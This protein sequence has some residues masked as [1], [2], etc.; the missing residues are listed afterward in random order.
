MTD[1]QPTQNKDL[2]KKLQ[3]REQRM[4]ALLQEA[5]QAQA[6]ALDRFRRAEA[7]LQTRTARLERAE[8]RLRLVRQQLEVL[9][10]SSP[11]VEP[12]VA[13]PTPYETGDTMG[14]T[15][16][17]PT[18]ESDADRVKEARAAAGAT[19]ENV[20]RAA[21]RAATVAQEHPQSAR[22]EPAEIAKIEAEEESVEAVAAVTIAEI[23]A[24]R[25]AE[26]E[27]LAEASSA[28]TREA[29]QRAQQA[30]AAL[31]EVRV[32]IRDGLLTGE[33]AETALQNAER[34][35]TRAQALLADAEAAEEQ[36]LDTAMNAEADAEVAEG[37]AYAV[38]D[39]A[40]PPS[41]EE[42]AGH[43]ETGQAQEVVEGESDV[44][45]KIPLVRP[46]ENS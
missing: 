34:E 23:A 32:A 35:V 22:A 15:P 27:A 28:Q 38:V 26:A 5:Q 2:R 33:E 19:E 46:Q 30:E 42:Q 31:G 10:A 45:I 8:E 17:A 41:G 39:R 18:T 24:E 11:A 25:A 1:Q 4:L 43:E 20:R 12:P 21:E 6:N 13:S 29:R 44:T 9:H 36:A 40:A 3:K 14:S 7:R 16:E 37:M